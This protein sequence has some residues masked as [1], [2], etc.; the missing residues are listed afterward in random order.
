M[1]CCFDCVLCDLLMSKYPEKMNL[2]AKWS[3]ISGLRI[4]CGDREWHEGGDSDDDRNYDGK[5]DNFAYYVTNP[6]KEYY[7]CINYIVDLYFER[8]NIATPLSILKDAL[9]RLYNALN[10]E[11]LV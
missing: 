2:I 4:S 10:E 5:F 11:G 7:G 6:F 1:F 3:T 8:I 9:E